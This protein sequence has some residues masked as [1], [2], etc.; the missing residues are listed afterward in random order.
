[1]KLKSV[2]KFGLSLII[3]AIMFGGWFGISS[4]QAEA[5]NFSI[6]PANGTYAVGST[7][8][9]SV[10][11]DTKGQEI[12]AVQMALSFPADKLQLVS[13]STGSSIISIYTTPPKYDNNTG[14]VEII[15]GI[16]NGVNVA[17]G[18]IAKLTFRVK[19]VGQAS[20]RFS[21]ESQILLNDGRG[22]N[23]LE[24]TFGASYKLELPPQQGP[25][26]V[27]STHPDQELWYR[28]SNV[29]LQWDVG[30][31]AAE[32]YSYSISNNP[33]DIPDDVPESNATSI[34][35]KDVPGGTNY[36]HI[37]AFREGR[38]GGV[39]HYS[40]RVDTTP[41]AEF[42]LEIL[43]GTRTFIT[44]PIINFLTTDS[45]SGLDHYEIN[46]IPLKIDGRDKAVTDEQ[47]FVDAQ[48]PYQTP[49]LLQGNYE[50][51]V[52]AY[53]KAGNI[54]EV[55]QKLEITDS[56]LW[57]LSQDGVS[58]P[59]GEKLS[60]V[61][62]FP[63][64]ILL[65][66]LLLVIAYIIRRWYK[67]AHQKLEN[68]HL[69]ENLAAQLEE[70]N[71]YRQRYGKI[72]SSFVV[73]II[74]GSVLF[75]GI[76]GTQAQTAVPN[77]PAVSEQSNL[78]LPPVIT[79]HSA[80]IKDDEL[81]YISGRTTEPNSEVIVHLQSMVTGSAFDFNTTSDK[82]G[83]W[84]YRHYDFLSGGQYIMWAHTKV[85]NQL[86]SPSPQVT[87]DVKPVA[88]NWGNSRITYQSIYISV[89][90]VLF[91]LLI[92]LVAYIII[93]ALLIR[94]RRKLFAERLRQTEDSLKRGFIALRRD[95]EAE[96]VLMKR[97][98]LS[99]Q[100]SGEQKIRE[101]ELHQDLK[102]IEELV[103]KEMW[104]VETFETLPKIN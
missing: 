13:P 30:F 26:V 52:R 103:G 93:H 49:D 43:P 82:R 51:L 9:V 44:K 3:A 7:F 97:A 19:G 64:L 4:K 104:E 29:N 92:L 15:G 22:T 33:T 11:V 76:A 25:I 74:A 57:F 47:L 12:N 67:L 84:M 100:L 60:W 2:H 42:T 34:S 31:P 10:I 61:I 56:W 69:P 73:M 70:L 58:L 37:K 32:N 85:G 41:P 94:H 96:L 48:S 16:P 1:M 91:I 87:M 54:R 28:N 89:I 24:N 18:L 63:L 80:N 5:A 55:S 59:F 95:I 79:S 38:W 40:L 39:S 46:I 78:Q 81:F 20:L 23:V 50:V 99:D 88:I 98:H 8:D 53:D 71:Q 77:A 62:V 21:G 68:N 75:S 90:V 14:R 6:T 65:L 86:S 101:E 36:F 27:S 72:A 83:D 45:H 102:N 17:S 35:Y 66:I